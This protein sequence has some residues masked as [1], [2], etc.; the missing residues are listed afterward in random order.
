MW[1]EPKLLGQ[2]SLADIK[3]FSIPKNAKWFVQP[4]DKNISN[5][6]LLLFLR[7]A[8]DSGIC[9]L[10]LRKC[11]EVTNAGLAHLKNLS[12]LELLN[13]DDTKITD[14]GLAHVKNLTSLENLVLSHTTITDAGVANLK[15]LTS[16]K[17]LDLRKT[18]ITEAGLRDFRTAR[19][20]V[21]VLY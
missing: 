12:S 20:D 10:S 9:G 15:I 6:D 19:P 4:I 18:Q 21:S 2:A 11:Q 5:E 7:D 16:L 14:T 8:A 3:K 1:D 13:L 17:S